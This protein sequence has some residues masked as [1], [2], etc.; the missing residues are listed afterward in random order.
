[1]P[2]SYLGRRF[3]RV[4]GAVASGSSPRPRREKLGRFFRVESLES[5]ALLAVIFPSG[6]INSI[7]DGS[8]TD[9]TITV[10]NSAAANA[11]IG[12]FWFASVPGQDYLTSNPISVTPPTGW[13]DQVTSEGSGDGYGIEFVA[14]SSAYDVQPGSS[15]SF[16]FTSADAPTLVE[17]NSVFY[18]TTAVGT[19]TAYPPTATSNNGLQFVVTAAPTLQSIVVTPADPDLP[20]GES[21]QLMAIGTFSNNTTANLTGQVTWASTATAMATVSNVSGSQGMATSVGQG[22][23]TILATL[24][25]ITATTVLTVSPPVLES[26]SLTP[27]NPFVVIGHAEQFT[28]TGTFSDSSTQNLTS[29]VNWGSG[30]TSAATISNVSGSQGL[31]TGVQDGTSTISAALDGITGT[32]VLVV[33][34][35]LKSIAVTPAD[36]TVPNGESDGF[37]ATGVFADNSTMNL[38]NYVTWASANTA[39]ATISNVAGSFGVASTLATGTSSISATFEGVT[40]S[41]LLTVSPAVLTSISVSSTGANINEGATDQLTASGLYSDNSTQNLTGLVTW[42]SSAPTVATVSSAGVASGVAQG[43][44]TI[45]ASYQGITGATGLTVSP[46]LVTLTNVDPVVERHRVTKIV[47]TFSGSLE[48]ALAQERELYRFVI[49][50]R[51]GVFTSKNSTVIRVTKADYTAASPDTVTLTPMTPFTL[52]KPVELRINGL[53]PS[54]LRDSLGRLIDGDQDGQSGGD[55]IAVLG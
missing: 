35:V 54:G 10:S 1:M 39:T 6:V 38:T 50:G 8:D 24:D 41:A 30:T 15:L 27:V 26:L 53:A 5:R 48:G 40:G 9:Y 46:P 17:G 55:A 28:A 20:D 19:S 32:G 18:P 45:S 25:G 43:V 47:L 37:T 16:S 3:N 42:S 14:S 44:A 33:T 34:P 2:R 36:P 31:A 29:E 22:P 4:F 21:V 51:K 49:S 23:T 52:S 12:T 7:P 11:G 13:T